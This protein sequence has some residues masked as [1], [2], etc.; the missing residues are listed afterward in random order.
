MSSQETPRPPYLQT[1]QE[2]R[3]I[4]L[5]CH[6]SIL[7]AQIVLPL[8]LW[9]VKRDESRFVDLHGKEALNFQLSVLIV[10]FPL[11]LSAVFPPALCVAVP[12]AFTIAIGSVVYGV[13][14]GIKAAE[15]KRYRYPYTFR[16]IT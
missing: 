9:L 1:T 2:E 3:I 16:L 7:F 14:A 13:L 5:L 6:V 10:L 8:I 11:T 15:G 12:A 4:A